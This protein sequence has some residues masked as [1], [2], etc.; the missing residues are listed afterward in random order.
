MALIDTHETKQ[1]LRVDS[2]YEDALI[3]ILIHSAETL[4]VDV[5]RM[6]LADWQ[7]VNSDAESTDTMSKEEMEQARDIMK[8]AIFYTVGYLN[9]HREEAD[10]HGLLLTLRAILA[11]IRGGA[12]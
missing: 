4:C 2:D 9:E 11:P 6:S 3:G 7:A 10:H 5:A 1:Y 12:F 8:V